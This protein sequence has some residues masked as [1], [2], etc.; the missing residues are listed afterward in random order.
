[1]NVL[2]TKGGLRAFSIALIAILVIA[3]L[4]LVGF[5]LNQQ[6]TSKEGASSQTREE[7][8][9]QVDAQ[10]EASRMTISVATE[11]EI[12]NGE[13]RV[14]VINVDT[15]K[16]AQTFTL[17]QD[18]VVLFES[19]V[20]APGESLEWCS[21]ASAHAG[22]AYIVIQAYE[23]GTKALQGSPQSIEVTLIG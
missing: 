6:N 10:T 20:L 2:T 14:N 18:D 5:L 4:C 3:C 19:D 17:V 8:Q 15:N 1:M 22:K 23:V 11:C 13:V 16:F 9:A 7:L 21:A 12:E